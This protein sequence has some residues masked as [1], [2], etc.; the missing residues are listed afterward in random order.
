MDT[1]LGKHRDRRT[2]GRAGTQ[3]GRLVERL[4]AFLSSVLTENQ[5]QTGHSINGTSTY[6]DR[7]KIKVK[8]KQSHYSPG[9][10]LRVPA[11]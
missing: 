11:G 3:K 8:V 2:G 1:H 6:G 5:Y 7:R 4:F 9:Q 10:A